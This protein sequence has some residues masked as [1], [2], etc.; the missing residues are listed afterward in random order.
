ML[1]DYSSGGETDYMYV[2]QKI[3]LAYTFEFRDKGN[4]FIQLMEMLNRF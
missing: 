2:V 4:L 1:T 3:P